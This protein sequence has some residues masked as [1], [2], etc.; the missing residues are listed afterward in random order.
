MATG[1]IFR[2]ATVLIEYST[3]QEVLLKSALNAVRWAIFP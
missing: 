2:A 3:F 1:D